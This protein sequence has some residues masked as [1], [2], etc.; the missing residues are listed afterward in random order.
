MAIT[1]LSRFAVQQGQTTSNVRL[2]VYPKYGILRPN[3]FN[4]RGNDA[5]LN[6]LR[7]HLIGFVTVFMK[8]TYNVSWVH[9]ISRFY[10][11]IWLKKK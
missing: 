6:M 2:H 11:E 4:E 5:V 3:P 7:L 9:I 8:T 1:Y 10:F